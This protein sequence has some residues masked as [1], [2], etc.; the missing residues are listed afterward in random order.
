[1][2]KVILKSTISILVILSGLSVYSQTST[3]KTLF[4]KNIIRAFDLREK[5]NKPLFAQ[6]NELSRNLLNAVLSGKIKAYRN[7]SLITELSNQ[8]VSRRLEISVMQ[9]WTDTLYMD[10]DEITDFKIA[11]QSYYY[12]PRDLYQ[13]EL[14]QDWIIDN[15]RSV[16][17]KENK[18]ISFFIP[19][20]HPDNLKG[21]QQEVFTVKYDDCEKIWDTNPDAIW[22]NPYNDNEHLSL[23]HAFQLELYSSYIVKVSNPD[24]EFL[25]DVFLEEQSI[26][27]AKRAE[28]RLME[29]ESNIWEN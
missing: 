22:F 5:Q 16:L 2:K 3:E 23:S 8:E 24:N 20:D 13:L 4:K 28:S 29:Y 12:G 9:D 6:N 25:A 18:S 10:P 27:E 21:F 11:N 7:D 14:N 19:A 15:Q 17:I 1:M 26:I